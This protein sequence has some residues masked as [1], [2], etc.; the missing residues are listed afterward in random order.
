[1]ETREDY[2]LRLASILDDIG[3]DQQVIIRDRV[4]EHAFGGN[5]ALALAEAAV[6]AR[7]HGCTFR[8]NRIK[9][10]GVF[11]RAYPAGGR[12]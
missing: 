4:I 7:A 12:A 5:G 11:I 3:A 9:Q 1:M 10:Q 2:Q 8:Y 6:F